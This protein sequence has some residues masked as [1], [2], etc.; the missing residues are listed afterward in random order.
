MFGM[1]T[2]HLA[3]GH[4]LLCQTIKLDTICWYLQATATE[5]ME[6]QRLLRSTTSK[7]M[8]IDPHLNLTT[9]KTSVHINNVLHEV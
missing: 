8:W 7:L 6:L 9:G 4:T 3:L 1:Y 5:I 2:A